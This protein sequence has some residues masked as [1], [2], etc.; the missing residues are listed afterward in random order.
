MTESTVGHPDKADTPVTGHGSNLP[1]RIVRNIFL[2]LLFLLFFLFI[3]SLW[4]VIFPP[5]LAPYIPQVAHY[6]T[7]QTGLDFHLRELVLH[8]GLSL[9]LEGKD[10]RLSSPDG[11]DTVLKASAVRLRFSPQ[12]WLQGWPALSMVLEGP[13]LN[14][15]RDRQG[16]VSVSGYPVQRLLEHRS[17]AR[18]TSLPLP[19]QHIV[20]TQADLSWQDESPDLKIQ[21]VQPIHVNK[22][23]ISLFFDPDGMMRW[24]IQGKLL[25]PEGNGNLVFNGVR[26]QEGTWSGRIRIDPLM[27]SL[28]RPYLGTAA[29]LGTFAAPVAVEMGFHWYGEKKRWHSRWQVHTAAAHVDFPT[30]FRW[31]LPLKTLT[32]RG[33]L[34]RD[35][36]Q[37]DLQVSRF[38]V[39]NVDGHGEGKLNLLGWGGDN[40][41][42]DLQATANGV[43]TDRAKIYFPA[44]IMNP[45]LVKWLDTSLHGGQVQ[46]ARVRIKGPLKDIPFPTLPAKGEPETL[47][48]IEGE[49]KGIGLT[50]LPGLPDLTEATARINVDRLGMV[51]GVSQGTWGT[52][53]NVGG[54]VRI[55]NM[56]N[57]PMVEVEANV[58]K[59][60]LEWM[61]RE[62]IANP[63]LRWDRRAGLHELKVSGQGQARLNLLLPLHDLKNTWFSGSLKFDGASLK[64]K[65]LDA[66]VERCKGGLELDP[67][68]LSLTLTSGTINNQPVTLTTEAKLY[69]DPKKIN[70]QG[71]IGTT[72]KAR[73]LSQWFAPLLGEDGEYQGEM[74]TTIRFK[75]QG[76]ADQFNLS[77][78]F[79]ANNLAIRG[80]L[81]WYKQAGQPGT[82]L[83][84]GKQDPSGA[85]DIGTLQVDLGNL[86]FVGSGQWQLRRGG[87]V[88]H[89]ARFRL[90]DHTGVLHLTQAPPATP[91]TAHPGHWRLDAVMD[92]L[93]LAPLFASDDP[94]APRTP[95]GNRKRQE[96]PRIDI[97]LKANHFKMANE[98]IGNK[99]DAHL[100]IEKHQVVL[101]HAQG[102]LEGTTQSMQGEI[103]WPTRIGTGPY[104]GKWRLK[105]DNAGLLFRGMNFQDTFMQGGRGTIDLTLEG[106]VPPGSWLKHH[107]SG[108]VGLKLNNGTI[109]RLGV[110]SPLLGLFSIKELPHLVT[111]DR[112]DLTSHGF[113]YDQ[114]HG[115][116]TLKKSVARL[117]EMLL[118][119]PSMQ[120]VLSG[121]VNFI[122]KRL[123]VLLG[124]RP[125]QS[126]DKLVSSVPLLGNLVTGDRK[127]IVETLFDIHGTMDDPKVEIRPVASIAPG[128]VR[129]LLTRPDSA[130]DTS[131]EG[132]QKHGKM[133]P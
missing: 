79:K 133:E 7:E 29:P 106:F 115:K 11:H 117:D 52:N 90:N 13:E 122:S 77:G 44:H 31:P 59:G 61:W 16:E 37:W 84:E 54:Q 87:G 55:G 70:L 129:D 82:V 127:A 4:L 43:P 53:N 23:R 65:F 102:E 71:Q 88:L 114:I 69:Q 80:A 118:E 27:L 100:M 97:A 116:A 64:P 112:P 8:P 124:I 35:K 19:I 6:L 67:H 40:P 22:T 63:Q 39:N 9:T 95:E 45:G 86:S 50:Y 26:N 126:L 109:A 18:P 2:L 68:Q 33:T 93:N 108:R 91:N 56:V 128:F 25:Q 110:L 38:V 28:L 99:L 96:W 105:S 14:L 66:P 62:V 15:R 98:I 49:V 131:Q 57:Q 83:L 130:D 125:I 103:H 111:M 24:R 92:W 20:V 72:L 107:L 41:R 101:Q 34:L 5:N 60:D 42:I 17:Q 85:L 32:A 132:N 10:I 21:P 30:L 12:Q 81:G 89:L 73:D 46:R 1:F 113:H 48:V 119:G 94:E 120:M 3:L 104:T 76:A 47:F 123:D 58:P 75:R 78:V 121:S 36:A 51:I 74:A